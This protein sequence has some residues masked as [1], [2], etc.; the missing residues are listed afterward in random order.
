[1]TLVIRWMSWQI[2]HPI[3]ALF[4][5]GIPKVTGLRDTM[6]MRADRINFRRESSLST[7]ANV[8]NN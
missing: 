7:S 8:Q 6:E 4:D 3:V 1:M 2:L 5:M